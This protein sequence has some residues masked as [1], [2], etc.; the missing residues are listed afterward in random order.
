MAPVTT[1]VTEAEIG[2]VLRFHMLRLLCDELLLEVL[3]G[4]ALA[5]RNLVKNTLR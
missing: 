5:E 2:L 4:W 3:L 1:E